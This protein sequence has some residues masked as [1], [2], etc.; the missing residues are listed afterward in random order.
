MF[1]N[2]SPNSRKTSIYLTGQKRPETYMQFFYME[3][4][5]I[6]FSVF[7]H[8]TEILCSSLS[9]AH[10]EESRLAD[11]CIIIK[12]LQKVPKQYQE[13]T[14]IQIISEYSLFWFAFITKQFCNQLHLPSFRNCNSKS[15]MFAQR[16]APMG[17]KYEAPSVLSHLS[18]L[19]S[20]RPH[21]V[22]LRR[23]IFSKKK[24]AILAWQKKNMD[25]KQSNYDTHLWLWC[26]MMNGKRLEISLLFPLVSMN[27]HDRL[28][29]SARPVGSSC[30]ACHGASGK[31]RTT[32]LSHKSDMEVS[33][34][35]S[36]QAAKVA[37]KDNKM[38]C[39]SK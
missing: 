16:P 9:C 24:L 32:R 34:N 21:R 19:L 39:Y 31:S 20:Q 10:F 35:L 3:L 38:G 14:N 12:H 5:H 26:I 4:D 6:G 27:I 23:L 36:P 29:D 25:T 15:V 1:K 7:K 18:P 28:Q 22:K 11:L 2:S 8:G 33:D 13:Y 30:H 37:Q 17:A